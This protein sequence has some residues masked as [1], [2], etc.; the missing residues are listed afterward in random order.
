VP[1]LSLDENLKPPLSSS[2]DNDF[3][4][5]FRQEWE[6]SL[7][8]TPIIFFLKLCETRLL[9]LDH[10]EMIPPQMTSIHKHHP[11]TATIATSSQSSMPSK[12]EYYFMDY[13]HNA[14]YNTV[15][16]KLA[17]GALELHGQRGQDAKKQLRWSG[18]W[19][20]AL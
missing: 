4:I 9:Y 10:V 17:I 18:S 11:F 12:L 13:F 15:K 7:E 3:D 6:A 20:Y 19:Q 2:Q 16:H 14:Y 8:A 5:D 1:I